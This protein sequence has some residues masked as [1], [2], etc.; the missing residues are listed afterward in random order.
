MSIAHLQKQVLHDELHARPP[1]ALNAPLSVWH[2]VL[3]SDARAREL[4]REH[5]EALLIGRGLPP[6]AADANFH[7]V[8]LDGVTLRWEQHTEFVCWTFFQPMASAEVDALLA[9]QPP[10]PALGLSREWLDG[11]PG[12]C[13]TRLCVW[14]VPRPRDGLSGALRA[15]FDPGS[16]TGSSV[17]SHSSDLHTDM[18]VQADGCIRMLVLLGEVG[19]GPVTP[20]R[21]GRLVQRL[22]DIETYRAAALMGL[23]D[24]RASGSWLSQGEKE[25]AELAQL[26]RDASPADE[27]ALL[28]RLTRLAAQLESRYAATHTRFSASA[29]YFALVEQRLADISEQRLPGMQSL[30][31][32]MQRRLM[33]AMHTCASADRRQAALSQRIERISGLLRT[34]VEVEQQQSSRALLAGMTRRQDL[35]LKLQST[36]EGLSV[37]AISYYVLGLL[38]YVL[39]GAQKLGWP[40]SVEASIAVA[41]PLVVLAVWWSL[42]RLHHRIAGHA[43]RANGDHGEL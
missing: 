22:L 15:L 5:L 43:E 37:A 31:D 34:R 23:P 19:P 13:V 1:E 24:A 6:M 12:D 29:A 14:A 20:R 32:F 21:L 30:H 11:L 42:R 33:P 7:R 16:V 39:K 18:R 38:G 3:W 26:V 17:I 40:F 4:S 25:L 27:T 10:V 2:C 35:Q 8:H 36:V 41:V 9:G 28:D